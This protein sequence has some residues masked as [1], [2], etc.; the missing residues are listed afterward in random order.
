VS[1]ALSLKAGSFTESVIREMTRLN[2]ALHGPEKAVNFAQGFPDFEPP[3]ELVDAAHAA[4][5]AGGA[6]HQYATTWGA[7]AL[8]QAVAEKKSAEWG[9]AV[10]P[11]TEVTVACGATESMMA[12]ML[13]VVDPGD[14]VVIFE[15][16]YEN[17]G[18]DCILS[19]AQP[20]YVP[21]RPPDWSFDADQL[22]NAFNER[23]RAIVVNTP[24]NP[25]GK[26]YRRD[27]LELIAELCQRHDA[28]AITDE[29]YEHMVFE[30]EH[31]SMATLPGM[32]ERTITI[33]GASKTY[34]IT[35]WRIGWLIAPPRLT[36]GIRKVHDFLTVGAAH[37]LQIAVAAAL[38]FPPSFYDA[39]LEEY[40][41]RRD[42]IL[43]G[44]REVGFEPNPPAGAY[45]VMAGIERLTELDDVSF[46][47]RLIETAGVATVPGSSFYAD[48]ELG[49][50]QIRF[51]FPKRLP[52]IERG[53]AALAQLRPERQTPAG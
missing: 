51:S 36:A 11:E 7:P 27:E 38:K 40:R 10:D 52:T 43:R 21:L 31:V 2:L 4:L 16:F 48:R 23:T 37:P 44:L 41:E 39:L 45:Y 1:V 6:Y 42:V 18:P 33:S 25:T 14:E 20:R 26:V 28:V 29:I 13:A 50:H 30:G 53:L 19:G 22:R 35:G 5:S 46:A 15:P 32:R 24:N 34:S 47:R 9:E 8:R 17:Y 3:A 12:A 49:R